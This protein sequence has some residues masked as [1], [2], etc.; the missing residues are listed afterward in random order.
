MN[1]NELYQKLVELGDDWADKECAASML[2]EA[3]KSLIS[4][5]ATT[6]YANESAVKA[7]MLA[8]ASRKFKDYIVKMCKARK[9]ANK[10]KIRYMALHSSIKQEQH[11]GIMQA[12]ER[13]AE[14]EYTT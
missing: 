10:A 7:E 11:L 6:E 14:K 12:A 4:Q 13:K 2:E 8:R 1:Q 3:R 5:I 9:E